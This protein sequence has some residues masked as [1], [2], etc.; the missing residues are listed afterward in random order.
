MIQNKGQQWPVKK[1][2]VFEPVIFDRLLWIHFWTVYLEPVIFDCLCLNG[3][4]ENDSPKRS[5]IQR[6]PKWSDWT[7]S[8]GPKA[9]I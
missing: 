2:G 3:W 1:S 6:G 7:K 4:S 9:R 8:F 5:K